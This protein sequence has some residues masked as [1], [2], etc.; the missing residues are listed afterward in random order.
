MAIRFGWPGCMQFSCR[1]E[2]P[3]YSWHFEKC[4]GLDMCSVV[5]HLPSVRQ[6]RFKYFCSRKKR[7]KREKRQ[8]TGRGWREKEDGRKG[9]RRTE[10]RE[11]K[12]V[13]KDEEEGEILPFQ[14]SPW[15]EGLANTLL[16]HC[17]MMRQPLCLVSFFYFLKTEVWS[18]VCLT[19]LLLY[20]NIWQTI[21][22]CI[23]KMKTSVNYVLGPLCYDVHIISSCSFSH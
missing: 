5:E 13:K 15:W 3:S 22:Y 9:W 6:P 2:R 18:F 4:L 23:L 1:V 10:S 20:T 8:K 21:A 7:K 12:R 19:D 11:R 16:S 14:G 17:R